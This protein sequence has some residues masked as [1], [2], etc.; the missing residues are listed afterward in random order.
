[1]ERLT[2]MNMVMAT[3]MKKMKEKTRMRYRLLSHHRP[4]RK[5]NRNWMN[6]H[7]FKKKRSRKSQLR[8]WNYL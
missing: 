1:M 6:S 2:M 4:G 8:I 5:K 7:W 3:T